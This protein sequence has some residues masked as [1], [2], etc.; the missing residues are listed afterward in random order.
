MARSID[1]VC[2]DVGDGPA[3]IFIHGIGARRDLWQPVVDRFK[4]RYRCVSYDLRGHGESP[5]PTG[6]FT[7][8]NLVDDVERLRVR[9]GIDRAH[10]IGHSLGG[11]IGP[12]YALR[13]PGRT[14]S[15]GMLSTAAFRSEED[16]KKVRGVVAAMRSSGIAASLDTLAERWFT[17]SFKRERGDVVAARKKQVLDTDA[18]TFLNVFDIYAETEMSPWLHE[19][20]APALVMTGEFDGGCNPGLNTQIAAAMPNCEL[21]VLPGLKHAILLEAPSRVADE[22]DMFLSKLKATERSAP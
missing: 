1:C 9:L 15:L 13:Y 6:S 22:I 21:K 8:D 20:E 17:D 11:M 5:L 14:R 3:I 4:D 16:A 12:R 7:L 19:V 18:A 10:L 2:S